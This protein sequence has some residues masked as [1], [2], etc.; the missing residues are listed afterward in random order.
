MPTICQN[1]EPDFDA[2]IEKALGCYV[3]VLRDPLDGDRVFY[4]GKGGGTGTGNARVLAHFEEAR[5][6]LAAGTRP[7]SQKIQRIHAIWAAGQKVEWEVIRYGLPDDKS[8]FHVEAA[9]IDLLGRDNL[10]NAQ[11]GHHSDELG[12]LG[13][14]EVYRMA[15]PLVAPTRDYELVLLFNI[16]RALRQG[17]RSAYDATRGWWAKTRPHEHAT[18]AVGLVRGLS[19]CVVEIDRWLSLEDDARQRGFAGAPSD[20]IGKD[21]EKDKKRRGFEGRSFIESG[22]HEL[23][24]RNYR[25]ILAQVSGYWG[26]GNWIAVE[27]K[28]GKATIRRGVKG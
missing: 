2:R 26:F 23:L 3:Y 28:A 1:D 8:A 7:T 25:E 11:G 6:A 9:L 5:L 15:A 17:G 24:D 13:S 22:A 18:H 10:T 19:V 27:F 4:V 14:R 12:R 21:W 20:H 16:E